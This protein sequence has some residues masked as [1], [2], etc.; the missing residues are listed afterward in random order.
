[1]EKGEVVV[2]TKTWRSE[3]K[4]LL[5]FFVLSVVSVYLSRLFPWSVVEGPIVSLFGITLWMRLPLFWL[6]PTVTLGAA[7][8]RIYDVRYVVD[9]RGIECKI[10]IL[11]LQQRVTRIRYEDIRSVEFEQ[12]I[13]ER[14]LDIGSVEIGTAATGEL[15]IAFRGISAPAEVQ[16]MLQTE[17]DKRQKA[18][19]AKLSGFT[20]SHGEAVAS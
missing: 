12:T 6:I 5:L 18:M 17:R 20:S 14:F 16:E 3:L 11:G 4:S 2:I 15:E 13:L 10:G 9:S 7:I 8:M 19:R 1:M